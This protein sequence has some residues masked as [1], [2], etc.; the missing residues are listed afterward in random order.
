MRDHDPLAIS[1]QEIYSRALD[2]AINRILGEVI[3][4]A[5]R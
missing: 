5:G 4:V 3:F 1:A 2:I